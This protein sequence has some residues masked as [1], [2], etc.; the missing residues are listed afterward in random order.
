MWHPTHESILASCSGDQSC[1]IW[2]LRS[3]QN[4]KKIHAHNNEVL[5]LDFNKYENFIATGSTD[6]FIKVFVSLAYSP[7]PFP[8]SPS[9][10]R[11]ALNDAI[12]PPTSS[13]EDQVFT[14]PRKHPRQHKL[15]SHLLSLTQTTTATCLSKFGISRLR[16]RLLNSSTIQSSSRV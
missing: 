16:E 15:V 4:V 13:Q 3:G 9:I 2:D 6:N 10:C 7:N 11:L 14:L 12:R 5:T 8:G 1:K